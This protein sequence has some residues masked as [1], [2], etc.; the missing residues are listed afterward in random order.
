MTVK[1]SELNEISAANLIANTTA[2]FPVV[3]GNATIETLRA[4]LSSITDYIFASTVTTGN[5]NLGNVADTVSRTAPGT[6]NE[7][8]TVRPSM[9]INGSGSVNAF[10]YAA[11]A[12]MLEGS[13]G[14]SGRVT[15]YPNTPYVLQH[16]TKQATGIMMLNCSVFSESTNDYAA[17]GLVYITA[18]N[19]THIN[20]Y[21]RIGTDVSD[22]GDIKFFGQ[23]IRA[24]GNLTAPNVSVSSVTISTGA[25]SGA[26]TVAGGA[27]IGGNLYVGQNFIVSQYANLTQGATLTGNLFVNANANVTGN[28]LSTNANIRSNL[29]VGNTITVGN[30]VS[31]YKSQTTS[32]FVGS[33][34]SDGI[35]IGN[36]IADANN[37]SLCYIDTS[38]GAIA[39]DL[40][41]SQTDGFFKIFY[42]T[43]D[44]GDCTLTVSRAG[45]KSGA[46]GTITFND[47][48]DGCTLVYM[49]SFAFGAWYA[50]G[51]NGVTYA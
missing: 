49:G 11:M 47:V 35:D 48:G 31:S 34:L 38:S 12:Y 16:K 37:M 15:N 39:A 46:S 28:L 50:V 25:Y 8:I 36:T 7:R 21:V 18:G 3:S 29:V 19:T 13:P 5:I 20:A 24:N 2:I 4:N 9:N 43:A 51:T 22:P 17:P 42:M 45:W 6:T 1:I 27:G 40:G 33:Q 14:S 10:D 44:G 32:F 41:A 30:T 23:D 26:L